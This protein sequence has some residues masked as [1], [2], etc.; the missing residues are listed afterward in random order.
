M[1]KKYDLIVIGGGPMGLST[2]YQASSR[3]KNVLIIEKQGFLNESGSSAGASRQF[4]LQYAQQYM[5]EL[6][7]S[8]QNFWAD[9]QSYTFKTLIKQCGSL[10]FGDP[11]LSSQEGGIKAAEKVMD[12]LNIP[13]KPLTAEQIEQEFAFKNLPSDYRG[14][15]QPSGGIINLKATEEALFNAAIK[16]GRVEF[17]EYEPVNNIDAEVENAIKVST[18]TSTYQSSQLAICAGP[19]TNDLLSLFNLKV[20]INI[21]QMSSAYFRKTKAMNNLP[22]WFVFQK[23]QSSA[24]FYGFPEVDWSHPGY[25]RVA[26]D[27]PDKIIDSPKERTYTPSPESLSLDAQWVEKHM[28]GL[29]STPQFTSTCLISLSQDS[30]KELLLDY[31]PKSHPNS[32]NIVVYTAGWAAKFIPIL[33]DMINQMLDG[34]VESFDYGTYSI[35]RSNFT[36]EWQKQ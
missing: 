9:L 13:Y 29:D 15:F 10:W 11:S 1:S 23:P 8:S 19:Y 7:L 21:W 14:F 4:R 25:L 2:A 31:L 34:P 26:T 20:G 36:I 35:D 6:V 30:S 28:D 24:L 5:S 12:H 18:A 33:G 17:L 3:G 27:F 32:R 22:T 16:T